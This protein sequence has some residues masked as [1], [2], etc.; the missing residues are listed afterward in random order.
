MSTT[1]QLPAR[2]WASAH[3]ALSIALSLVLAAVLMAAVVLLVVPAIGAQPERPVIYPR[4]NTG[5]G[6][7]HSVVPGRAC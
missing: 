7:C 4:I 5:E 3:R 2:S 6:S 1:M